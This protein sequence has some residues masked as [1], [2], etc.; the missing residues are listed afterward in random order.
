MSNALLISCILK[1]SVDFP[2]LRTTC[3][4]VSYPIKETVTITSRSPVGIFFRTKSPCELHSTVCFG[5]LMLTVAPDIGSPVSLITLPLSSADG[6]LFGVEED[7]SG[8]SVGD[9][10]VLEIVMVLFLM[11]NR[12]DLS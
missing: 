1:T 10:A 12:S 9:C 7:C 5:A 2:S 11:L 3:D 6:L 8:R 4:C